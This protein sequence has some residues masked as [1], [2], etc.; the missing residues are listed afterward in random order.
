MR[1]LVL[2]EDLRNKHVNVTFICREFP[3]NLIKNIEGH[4]FKVW[5]LPAPE[6]SGDGTDYISWLQNNWRTDVQQTIE[7]IRKQSAIDWIII[8]HYALDQQWEHT[9]KSFVKRIM[10]IDDLADRLHDC[11]LLL[12]QN[13]YRN[14]EERYLNL[15]PEDA[16]ALL[17]TKHLLLRQEFRNQR[18]VKKRSS[19]VNRI[20][21]SFGGSDPTN[22]TMKALK[23]IDIINRTDI[24]VDVVVGLSNQNYSAIRNLSEKMP[25]TKIHYQID[26]LAELMAKADLAIGSGGS[27]TWERCFMGLPAVTIETAENQSEILSFLSELGVIC[28]FGKSQDLHEEDMAVHLK[29]LIS[30]PKRIKEMI[31]A[32]EIIMKD[33]E[34]CSVVKQLTKGE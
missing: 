17:G 18:C 34:N 21:I 33:Y 29:K 12:D 24:V 1:C 20:L 16:T 19:T 9:I 30:S 14:M 22:E 6:R 26:Y 27:T 3:G 11:H 5:S 28:H 25:Q 10:V 15:I 31:E 2:A 32:S 7:W 13:L 23:A 8:D 4:G